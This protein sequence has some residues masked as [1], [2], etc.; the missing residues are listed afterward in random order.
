MKLIY[1]I[2]TF[3]PLLSFS[4]GNGGKIEFYLNDSIIQDQSKC[5]LSVNIDSIEYN[6]LDENLFQLL[7]SVDS[8]KIEGNIQGVKFQSLSLNI[9]KNV[10]D[11]LIVKC[12]YNVDATEIG[13]T[14]ACGPT[15]V[16]HK[17]QIKSLRDDCTY[18]V[19]DAI[20]LE[21]CSLRPAYFLNEKPIFDEVKSE[22]KRR[23]KAY[24]K[25][26]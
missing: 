22:N 16:Y 8:F 17:I 14:V 15:P 18:Y 4:Q 23:K 20:R 3:F 1:L 5:F 21:K 12:L 24:R 10:S 11:S 2:I 19:S 7:L 13:I 9:M 25:R 6:L 26:N